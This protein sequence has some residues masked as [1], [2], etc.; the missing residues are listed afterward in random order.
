MQNLRRH[1][2]PANECVVIT[3]LC[4]NGEYG[5][6]REQDDGRVRGYGYSRF[7]AIADLVEMI[8][9]SDAESDEMFS[10]AAE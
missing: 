10:E 1:Y 3:G 8:G 6:Y 7:N 9:K 5:A 2:F 4:P